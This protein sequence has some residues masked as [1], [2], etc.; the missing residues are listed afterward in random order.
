MFILVC[1]VVSLAA[2]FIA[3][4]LAD[5]SVGSFVGVGLLIGILCGAA[6]FGRKAGLF[7]RGTGSPVRPAFRLAAIVLAVL[8]MACGA[9]QAIIAAIHGG[10]TLLFTGLNAFF[11]GV[12]F[13]VLTKERKDAE[14][15]RGHEP[16]GPAAPSGNS[17][18][19]QGPPS[20]S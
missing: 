11:M 15:P 12:L 9:I 1:L 16:N 3:Y 10:S 20:V 6:L 13:M 17:A 7:G 4:G 8:S 5:Y 14:A 19:G 2:G 18:G